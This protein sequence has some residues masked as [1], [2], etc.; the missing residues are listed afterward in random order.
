MTRRRTPAQRDTELEQF[1]Q[2]M[3]PPG[4]FEEGF[5]VASLI[6]AIFVG[7][8]MVP[9]AMYLGLLAGSGVGPA[10]QWV[11][12]ILFMEVARRAHKTLKHAE[13]FVLFYI[14]GAV[15]ANPF[16]GLLWSQFLVQSDAAHAAGVA[17]LIPAWVAPQAREVLAAR[18]FFRWEWLAPIGLVVFAQFFGRLVSAVL[19]YGLFRLTSD[20]EELPFPMAPV[21]AQG[22]VALAEESDAE[23]NPLLGSS[24]PATGPP[25]SWRWRVFSVGGAMGILFGVLYLGVPALTGA[26]LPR[27][28]QPFPIPFVDWTSKTQSFLPAVATGLC[29][30][31][32]EI[33]IG[34]VLPF[35]AMLGS[36]VALICTFALNPILYHTGALPS[37][38]P[39]DNTVQTLFK[40]NVDFYFSFGIGLSLAI[41]L[42]GFKKVFDGLRQSRTQRETSPQQSRETR[43]KVARDR[44][45]IPVRIILAVYLLSTLAYILVSGY[46][47]GWHRGV[48]LVM[49]FYGFVYTPLISY[50]TARL[51]GIAG[52]V[53]EIPMIREASFILSGYTGV[54][55]W[56]LPI[57]M[58]NYGTVTVLFRQAELTG[59]R[60]WSLWKAE[61]VLFPI[62]L[63]SSILF[64]DLIWR[65]A[66]IPSAVYPF[67]QE[68]W[69]FQAANQCIIFSATLGEY[70]QFQE[71]F[72]P[73]I[74]FAGLG[75]G[76]SLFSLTSW[77]AFPVF[78]SYGVVRGLGQTMPHVVIPQFIGALLGRYY[79][80]KRLGLRWRQ[81]VPVVAAGFS[82]GVGLIAML[83]VGITFL[84]KAVTTL[85]Y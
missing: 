19:G 29:F 5:S 48:M 23:S 76:L 73:G 41:A 71:A 46:L 58:A 69:E 78:F 65:M 43:R 12:V 37:W 49:F 57:P 28:I 32:G 60:F 1:R 10:A 17:E 64:S 55:V 36:F 47:I 13:I 62:I 50:V 44:G 80:Q 84:A 75:V 77:L 18:T 53:V 68:M 25:V 38:T 52:Q 9:G 16:S 70:S 30:D 11:T 20:I 74:L 26:V 81:Y 63:C 79:F 22:I 33:L 56:F 42:I 34:M 82:C 85:P 72:R 83:C 61:I 31:L 6:G 2:L 4:R 7:L 8:V 21:G 54:A 45:D 3:A 51:E 66:P 15:M 14:A 27:P 39:G 35:F 24:E 40:N 67:A 59:T